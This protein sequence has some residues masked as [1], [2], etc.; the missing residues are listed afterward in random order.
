MI[1]RVVPMCMLIEDTVWTH[2]RTTCQKATLPS[3]ELNDLFSV[4]TPQ[5]QGP[6]LRAI[7]N[8][9]LLTKVKSAVYDNEPLSYSEDA[10]F[11]F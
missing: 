4:F 6:Q 11:Y 8:E 3:E 9:V 5:L 10:G 1:S 7:C 2:H